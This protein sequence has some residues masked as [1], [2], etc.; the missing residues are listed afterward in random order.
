MMAERCN[1]PTTCDLADQHTGQFV[2]VFLVSV[3]LVCIL[4]TIAGMGWMLLHL[5]R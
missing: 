3:L 1:Q 5:A 2:P 4:S